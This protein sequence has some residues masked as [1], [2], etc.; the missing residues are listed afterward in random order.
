MRRQ[1]NDYLLYAIASPID[2]RKVEPEEVGR[3]TAISRKT[4][5]VL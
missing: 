4:T 5:G 1:Y 2:Q 3:I